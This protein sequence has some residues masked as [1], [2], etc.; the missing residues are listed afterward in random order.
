MQR[1]ADGRRVVT[2]G[3]LLALLVLLAAGI[4]AAY[5]LIVIAEGAYLGPRAVAWIYDRGAPT[6]DAVKRFEPHD[7]AARLANPLLA[8]LEAQG[9]QVGHVLD[10]AT[11]TG[12]LMV[13]VLSLPFFRGTVTGLDLSA[14]MLR[15]A[16]AKTADWPER[17]VLLRHPAHPLPF[18][19]GAF[20]A[21]TLLEALEFLPDRDRALR[22]IRRVLA[23]GGWLLVTNRRGLDRRLLPGRVDAPR[24]FAARLRAAGFADVDREDWLPFY[25]L[26]WARKPGP[27]APPTVRPWPDALRC[28]ACGRAG[29]WRRA[30]TSLCCTSCGSRCLEAHRVWDLLACSRS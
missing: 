28:P 4:A 13:S 19:D 22:E 26:V 25:D 29:P 23:P 8:R 1:P 15:E 20:D 10:V 14:G 7:E 30:A 21:A 27:A 17:S 2:A 3:G 24:A 16:A 6:Y 18:E 5:W 9:R 12:R 11:G